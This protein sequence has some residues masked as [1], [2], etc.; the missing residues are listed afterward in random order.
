MT[1]GNEVSEECFLRRRVFVVKG[2]GR[3]QSVKKRKVT[4]QHT[5]RHQRRT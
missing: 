2:N 1:K 4:T 3:E 5:D